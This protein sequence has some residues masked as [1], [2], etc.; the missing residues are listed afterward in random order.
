MR[1]FSGIPLHSFTQGD[2]AGNG[3][4]S[5]SAFVS[6][7]LPPAKLREG[8]VFTGAFHSVCWRGPRVT[9]THDVLGPTRP[10]PHTGPLL[11]TS[12][13]HHWKP[14]QTCSLEELPISHGY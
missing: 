5:H 14:I 12:G 11:L 2:L 3:F 1:Y 7:I 10:T 9:I 4:N 6:H 8:N 13:G